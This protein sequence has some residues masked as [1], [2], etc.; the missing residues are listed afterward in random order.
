MQ[1]LRQHHQDLADERARLL[2]TG[3]LFDQDAATRGI[4]ARNLYG[5][6]INPES[7][8][9]T[10][11][12]LWLH[13]A[14][15][16][17]PLTTLDDHIRCGNSLVG[18]DYAGF[19]AARHDSLF[20]DLSTD[21]R[22]LVNVFDWAAEFPGVLGPGLPAADRGFDC[23]IGNPPYVKLQHMR[24]IKE[25]EVAYLMEQTRSV[26][27]GDEKR[28]QPLYRSTRTGN[29]DLYLPFIERGLDL[30]QDDGRMG[31]IAPSVWLKNEYGEGLKELI[32]E[33]GTLDRWVDFGHSQVFEDVTVYTAL[34]FFAKERRD[35]FQFHRVD[36][37]AVAELEWDDDTSSLP[38]AAIPAAEP[39]LLMGEAE[40]RLFDRLAAEF[41]RLDD[42]RLT[43]GI[44]VGI[45]TSADDFYH[46]ERKT[47]GAFASSLE[48][49]TF[50]VEDALMRPLVSGADAKRYETPD[51]TTHLLFP[52][53]LRG[54][55][56]RLFTAEEMASRFP[57][58]WAYLKRHEEKLRA[59]ERRK[60]DGDE[61]WWAYNYPKNLD[62]QEE[63]KL[64][65]PRLVE[66]LAA[67]V[68][69]GGDFCL[70]NVDVG[71]M[72]PADVEDTFYL[73]G[74]LNSPVA[75]FMFR[76]I[77]KP[78]RGGYFA[79]N[80]QF[81][82]SIPVPLPDAASR[83]AVGDAARELQRLTTERRDAINAFSARIDSPQCVPLKLPADW[84]W[85]DTNQAT[86]RGQAPA[87]LGVRATNAWIK[88]TRAARLTAHHDP[89]DAV[90]IPD[91][92]LTVIEEDGDLFLRFNDR[93]LLT[94]YALGDDAPWLAALWRHQL[95]T[96]R[97]T[98][99]PT[100]PSSPSSS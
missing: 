73:L 70:D 6:D 61:I 78:F 3:V 12:A 65:V 22:D 90:L 82:A 87:G 54:D 74:V 45:Q 81:I 27:V 56:P 40:R 26:G 91:A 94:R 53:D 68:D 23:V 49:A 62:K 100:P 17:Q 84:L 67:A 2:G 36:G 51:T 28:S 79:A 92:P 46:L 96:N 37:N 14:T 58:G 66:R 13:T 59:R 44:T 34:Q 11:L 21:E 89:I 41:P 57:M 71:G 39:W 38:V 18:P 24:K 7:V 50:E 35:A 55:R 95:R 69:P 1:F 88:S 32:A 52:Y 5:V 85:A 86:I 19:Y 9:I 31:Y 16:G 10:Q 60:M 33:R 8:E 72:L 77:S 93:D 99:A 80:K 75:D 97:I 98:P 20:G 42:E 30:L 64:L 63:V 43:R 29:F 47:G 15:K 48:E 4:L 76:R 25:D 83:A